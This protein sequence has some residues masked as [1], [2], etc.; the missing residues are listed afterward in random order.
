MITS[1]LTILCGLI[2]F[3]I[4]QYILKL[5]LEPS[6]ELRKSISSVSSSILL[7]QAKITNASINNDIA[8]EM[9]DHSANI[10]S[11]SAGIIAYPLAQRLFNLP[12][13][14]EIL[15]ASRELNRLFYSML[16]E[17]RDFEDSPGYHAK[18]IDH[19]EMNYESI[20]KISKLLKIPTQYN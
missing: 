11:K 20:I 17:A 18:K 12:S 19:A 2:V 6:V 3:I 8:T 5:I 10:L 4:S 7:H 14:Y 15:D 16:K 1:F 9:K 13:K